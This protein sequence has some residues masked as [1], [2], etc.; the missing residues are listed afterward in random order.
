MFVVPARGGQGVAMKAIPKF[1]GCQELQ[2]AAL[3]HP[4]N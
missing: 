3:Q 4:S 2:S 1:G